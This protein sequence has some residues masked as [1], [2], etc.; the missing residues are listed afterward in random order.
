M[1]QWGW[2]RIM[3][4]ASATHGVLEMSFVVIDI[5]QRL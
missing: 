2:V 5:V 4:M 1:G 3:Y